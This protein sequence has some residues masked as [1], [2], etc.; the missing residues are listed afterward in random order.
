MKIEHSPSAIKKL[1][2]GFVLIDLL[3]GKLKSHVI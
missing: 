1:R 3:L 2:L